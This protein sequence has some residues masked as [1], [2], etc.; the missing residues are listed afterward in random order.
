VTTPNK[1][2]AQELESQIAQLE[3]KVAEDP[4][5]KAFP[6]LADLYTRAGRLL[7]AI[8]VCRDG[9]KR[10]PR[11]AAGHVSLG[12][13]LF[14]SGNL[15]VAAKVL[16]RSLALQDVQAE[17]FR[18]LGEIML[19]LSRPVEAVKLLGRARARGF[20]ERSIT[21]LLNKA[22]QAVEASRLAKAAE[23]EARGLG[24]VAISGT[25]NTE[26]EETRPM[27][28]LTREE[29]REEEAE[30]AA[31]AVVDRAP[32]V[33]RG[34][35]PRVKTDL[36]LRRLPLEIFRVEEENP[37]QGWSSIDDAWERTLDASQ[38]RSGARPIKTPTPGFEPMDVPVAPLTDP[39]AEEASLNDSMPPVPEDA[40]DEDHTAAYP[41]AEDLPVAEEL[42]PTVPEEP[43][44]LVDELAGEA[45][46]G[47]PDAVITPR[48]QEYD[49]E[50]EEPDEDEVTGENPVIP[51][52]PEGAEAAP[53][54]AE[55]PPPE[56]DPTGHFEGLEEEELETV[57]HLPA[58][59]PLEDAEAAGSGEDDPV[60]LDD[61]VGSLDGDGIEEALDDELG[62]EPGEDEED[63]PTIRFTRVPE[64]E[65]FLEDAAPPASTT[66]SMT[67]PR[68]RR[69]RLLL[70][71]F[72]L[73]VLL[74]FGVGAALGWYLFENRVLGQRCPLP[75][76]NAR[77]LS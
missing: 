7:D 77:V 63:A 59:E 46:I 55:P 66:E 71:L 52:L 43:S 10:H 39:L 44:P 49:E 45:L 40:G 70:V 2:R 3:A 48:L 18:L 38:V 75:A 1:S 32:V 37:K 42:V 74:L 60:S 35:A 51:V 53:L 31:K 64:D 28:A 73:G 67:A 41:G 8:Q 34:L 4:D 11:L 68:R 61:E 54:A 20:S 62:L 27:P 23:D 12:R 25:I 15:P 47:D 72:V 9:L 26:D 33:Q 56:E 19:R 69:G 14:G 65:L 5:T 16:H 29:L 76:A 6:E 50:L 13:A 24:N 17:S 30:A 36:S 21:V 57:P 58:A 22:K